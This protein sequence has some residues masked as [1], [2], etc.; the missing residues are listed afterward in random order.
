MVEQPEILEHDS[1]AP[2]EVRALACRI[3]GNISSEKIDEAARGTQRHIE[4]P[5]KGRLSGAGGACK[6]VKRSGLQMEVDIAQNLLPDSI[7]ESDILESNKSMTRYHNANPAV[8]SPG[9]C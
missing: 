8:R 6:K 9:L 4:E 3:L 7:T 2:P 1:N 5:E